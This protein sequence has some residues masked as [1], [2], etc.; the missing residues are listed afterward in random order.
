MNHIVRS[1]MDDMLTKTNCIIV[2]KN[3]YD[4]TT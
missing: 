2:D 1:D 3:C 4:S